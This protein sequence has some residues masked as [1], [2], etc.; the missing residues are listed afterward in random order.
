MSISLP[1]AAPRATAAVCRRLLTARSGALLATTALLLIGTAAGLAA[2]PALGALVDAVIAAAP[3]RSL[4][5]ICAVILASGLLSAFLLW[6]GGRLLVRVLQD[7]LAEL[8]E[9]VFAAA[10]SLD[11]VVV[12]GAGSADVVSRVTGDVEAV[13]EAVSGV[14]PRFVQATFTI[15]LTAVGLAA[16]DPWLALAASAAVP[17]QVLVTMRFLRRSRPLYTRLRREEA[18]RG[19]SVIETVDGARTVRAY[20]VQ[21]ERLSRIAE[22]SLIAVETQRDAAR[23]RNGF[24]GGLN[25]AEF[26][27]LAGILAVGFLRVDAG[28]LTVGAVTAAALFFHRLFGPIGALLG[29]LDDLQRAQAGLERLVGLAGAGRARG[30][31]AEEIRDAEV[32]IQGV[33]YRYPAAEADA[34]HGVG[35]RLPAGTATVLVGASGSGKSTLARIVAGIHVPRRGDVLIGGVPAGRARYRGRPAVQLVTQ[36]VRLFDGT[37]ADNLLL[38][39]PDATH[40]EMTDSLVA[41][42]ATW[43]V[44]GLDRRVGGETDLLR[45]Q[46]IALARVLLADPPVVVLDEASAQGGHGGELDDALAAVARGRTAIVVAHRLGQT[47]SADAVAVFER[48]AIVEKGKRE[49]LIRRP[50][51]V[52]ARLWAASGGD[53]ARD[54]DDGDGAGSRDGHDGV[55]GSRC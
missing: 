9:D 1:V 47:R 54:G 42:G 2:P 16:L 52:F 49:D 46:Q 53:G 23:V 28:I 39:R 4:V 38:G 5:A 45:A 51:G 44:G 15:V 34:L 8:R 32:R 11:P 36:E 43:A 13:T 55:D 21:G 33:S 3:L 25:L 24:N 30:E 31:D 27:G 20:G 41:V 18:A 50:G 19:Q 26:A 29:S 22:L 40:R 12:E 37:L 14:L 17:I 10:V 7:A 48:G 6:T 35:L